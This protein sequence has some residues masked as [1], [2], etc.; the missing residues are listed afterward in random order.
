MTAIVP[1]T[2]IPALDAA[3]PDTCHTQA[4]GRVGCRFFITDM[5]IKTPETPERTRL[6]NM[7]NWRNQRKT[8]SLL[9]SLTSANNV[10]ICVAVES[11]ESIQMMKK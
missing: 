6:M 8:Q 5:R 9:K 7:K 4:I 3:F 10:P 1:A 11:K 2:E